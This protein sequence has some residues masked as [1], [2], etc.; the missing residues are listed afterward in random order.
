[1]DYY[2]QAEYIRETCSGD[3]T[4]LDISELVFFIRV[5]SFFPRILLQHAK[6]IVT[7]LGFG[8]EFTESVNVD[9]EVTEIVPRHNIDD[10]GIDVPCVQRVDIVYRD[11]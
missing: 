2:E 5:V 9:F 7:A 1:M 3:P 4:Y 6:V 8:F 11:R 10:T